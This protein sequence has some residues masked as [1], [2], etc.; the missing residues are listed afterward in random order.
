MARQRESD[1]PRLVDA[2]VRCDNR[3][4][5][6]C[7]VRNLDMHGVFVLGRDGSL[8][9]LPKDSSVEVAL[10]LNTGGK[11][12]THMLRARVEQKARDGTGLVFTDADIDTFSA[13]LH[14]DLK[15]GGS[16]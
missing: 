16:L 15:T 7:D 1:V 3:G 5:Q 9:K 6:H 11:T 8:T 12:K 4:F 14:L 2:M 10:K 13:L